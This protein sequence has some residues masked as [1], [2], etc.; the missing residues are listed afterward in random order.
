MNILYTLKIFMNINK[1]NTEFIYILIQ[2]H[3]ILK[4]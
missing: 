3:T 1:Q 4:I 2:V